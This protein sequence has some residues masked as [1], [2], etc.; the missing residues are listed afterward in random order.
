EA[1]GHAALDVA[2]SWGADLASLALPAEKAALKQELHDLLLLMA[3]MRMRRSTDP[4]AARDVLALLEKASQHRDPTASHHRLAALA[5]R[6]LA[7]AEKA[8]R[9][10]QLAAD[11]KTP[12]T[13]LD[14]FLTGLS[15]QAE[16]TRTADAEAQAD[17]KAA[18]EKLARRAVEQYRLALR[19]E[20]NHYWAHLQLGLSYLALGQRAEAA[21]ALNACVALRPDA[22]WGY[23]IRGVA[24]VA[25]NRFDDATDDLNRAIQFSPDFRLPRLN[26][27]VAFWLQRKYD[28][29]LADFDA[30]SQPPES[31]RLIEA[32][33]YRGH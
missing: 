6:I 20:P 30:V 15:L 22:P 28:E 5:H 12:Q 4:P 19:K 11:P 24:L 10:E 27:G 8:R 9:F 31:Q 13:A 21:E 17:G 14:H 7:D 18:R 25:Q 29:A 16:A 1:R 3:Q 33:Y 32:V 23:S 26:R 2:R